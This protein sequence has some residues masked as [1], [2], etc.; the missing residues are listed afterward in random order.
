MKKYI[1]L[2]SS[3]FMGVF[4]AEAQD[5]SCNINFINLESG[6]NL[7]QFDFSDSE[8]TAFKNGSFSPSQHQA[9]SLGFNLKGDLNLVLGAAYDKYQVIGK[10]I[11]MTSSH[12]S[13]DLNYVS[14]SAGLEYS[15]PV[16]DKI[17]LLANGAVTYNYLLSGFQNIGSSSYDL[18]DS[19]FEASSYSV[20]AGVLYKM[21]D[22]TGIYLK[23]DWS[24]TMNM[25][26]AN[27]SYKLT[28]YVYSVG[29]RFTLAK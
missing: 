27:D 9:L 5:K 18:S 2:A 12:L 26:D 19:D 17:S 25:E 6:I 21:T 8:I 3:L 29:I 28:S 10:S 13:Y 1:L 16:K 23:Y 11:D 4:T 14:S 20:G 24:K 15:F 7:S 22:A